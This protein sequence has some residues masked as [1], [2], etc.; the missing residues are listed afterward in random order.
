M[1]SA[2]KFALNWPAAAALFLLVLLYPSA[3]ISKKQEVGDL[4]NQMEA[5]YTE[6]VKS[7][8]ISSV[9]DESD[10]FFGQAALWSE[11][12][13]RIAGL[14][15]R[16]EE[17]KKDESVLRFSQRLASR[18]RTIEHLAKEEKWEG[19]MAA[20]FQLQTTCMG[21]HKKHRF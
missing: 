13:I 9:Q 18:S 7:V 6:I 2:G 21:C 16:L 12:I 11:E 15:P 5:A 8:M 1:K 4:M 14:L 17:Y 10:I 19:M 3:G 20:L